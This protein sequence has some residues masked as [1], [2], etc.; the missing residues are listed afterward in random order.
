MSLTNE[1]VIFLLK[2][3]GNNLILGRSS[4]NSIFL[5]I[6]NL[7]ERNHRDKNWIK[8]LNLGLGTNGILEK[9]A[10]FTKDK[11]LARVWI[12]LS[13]LMKISS[14][15]TGKKILE[16]ADNLDSNRKLMEK[17][18]ST[19]KA[20]RYKTLFLGALTSIFLGILAGL[21]PLFVTFVSIFRNITINQTT[22]TIMPFSLYFIT[23]SSIYFI[24][25]IG[26]GK[27]DIKTIIF[28]TIV[29]VCSFFVAKAILLLIL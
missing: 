19:L 14:V 3:I 5:A 1:E 2:I 24:S 28:T 26:F 16:I 7:Q 15:E 25:D 13:K 27:I 6:K 18:N 29:Y 10:E 8:L 11:S 22:L 20:Q 23:I 9:L 17:R 4:E 21:A 12:L